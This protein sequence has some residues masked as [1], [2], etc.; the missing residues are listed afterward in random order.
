[1]LVL[2]LDD[3]KRHVAEARLLRKCGKTAGAD[4]K[5]RRDQV[6]AMPQLRRSQPPVL[7]GHNRPEIRGCKLDLDIFAPVLGQDRNASAPRYATF[8]ESGCE[9]ADAPV[10]FDVGVPALI[11]YE[12]ASVAIARDLRC[13]EL[14]YGQS[15]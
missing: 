3:E 14:V 15:P 8:M 9:V 7:T 11:V 5:H 10:E 13:K 12:R 1:L 2:V 6:D 4:Q